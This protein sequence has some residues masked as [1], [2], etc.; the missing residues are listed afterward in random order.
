MGVLQGWSDDWS[1]LPPGARVANRFSEKPADHHSPLPLLVVHQKIESIVH[2]LPD[3]PSFL[4]S[5]SDFGT[6]LLSDE[7]K[8]NLTSIGLSNDPTKREILLRW[9]SL[10]SPTPELIMNTLLPYPHSVVPK[11]YIPPP[12]FSPSLREHSPET[13]YLAVAS[14]CPPDSP[15]RSFYLDSF[16]NTIVWPSTVDLYA[17][18]KSQGGFVKDFDKQSDVW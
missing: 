13:A 6:L 5:T 2:L 16:T 12:Y 9:L 17:L 4:Y 14:S 1:S 7:H 15:A 10:P 3:I 8:Q 11:G 18:P